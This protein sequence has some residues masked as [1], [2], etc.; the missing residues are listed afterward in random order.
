MAPLYQNFKITTLSYLDWEE[1]YFISK[2]TGLL[3]TP[4]AARF[5]NFGGPTGANF[6]LN[7]TSK[8]DNTVASYKYANE[9]DNRTIPTTKKWS[10]G[11]GNSEVNAFYFK[12]KE[13]S[14]GSSISINFYSLQKDILNYQL[15]QTWTKVKVLGIECTGSGVLDI[16]NSGVSNPLGLMGYDTEV[17][18][19][20]VYTMQT[21][22][23]IVVNSS[24]NSIR[25]L[26]RNNFSVTARI[27]AMGNQ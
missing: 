12:E 18:V 1:K 20:G 17:G 7:T 26:N 4:K 13:L 15:T 11:T 6:T 5:L 21:H 22:S 10:F 8:E 23:G 14:A 27:L 25:V 19:S 9:F 2:K 24:A 3:N 16:G